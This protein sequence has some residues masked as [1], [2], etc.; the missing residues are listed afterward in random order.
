MKKTTPETTVAKKPFNI[1]VAIRRIGKAVEPYPKAALFELAAEGYDSVFEV[2]AACIISVRTLDEVTL[3]T[4]RR[5]FDRARTP[6]QVAA[7]SFDEIDDLIHACTFHKPKTEQIRQI[8]LRTVSDF[9]GAVPCD[10]EALL[11][12]RGVGPKCANLVL[13]IACNKPFIGVDI[14]VHR[15]TNRWGY[16]SARTPEKTMAELQQT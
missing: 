10:E 13:G 4:A 14:H 12:F 3:P 2:L 11:S 1:G 7:L 5:L 9:G 6:D 15:I 8:A 16:V